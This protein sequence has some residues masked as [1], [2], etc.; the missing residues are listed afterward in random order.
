MHEFLKGIEI[1]GWMGE[2]EMEYLHN[3]VL[4]GS[5]DGL[6]VE[7]GTWKGL[8]TA[9]MYTARHGNQRIVTIDSWLGQED[10]RWGT[11]KECLNRDVFMDFMEYMS[12]LDLYPT[13]YKPNQKRGGCL[14]LRALSKDAAQLFDDGSLY[15]LFIDGDH[16]G[17]GADIDYFLPKL[18]PDA[19]VLGHDWNWGG[20]KEQ[21]EER[22]RVTEIIGDMWIAEPFVKGENLHMPG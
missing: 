18:G 8:S 14:Y 17:V 12:A 1:P 3:M 22:V 5:D 19:I 20:V 7:V 10:I 2:A 4:N 15:R 6:F 11:H 21:V 16:T 9:A 13:W